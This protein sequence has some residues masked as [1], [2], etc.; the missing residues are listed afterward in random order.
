MRSERANLVFNVVPNV[1][2]C[3][4]GRQRQWTSSGEI[5][6]GRQIVKLLDWVWGNVCIQLLDKPVV[7]GGP[8]E[9]Q[10]SKE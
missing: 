10:R 2:L 9:G 8:V 4:C 5:K 6:L 3:S 7:T 1:Q